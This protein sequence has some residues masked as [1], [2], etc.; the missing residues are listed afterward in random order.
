M[1]SCLFL[2]K[3]LLE[4]DGDYHRDP[5]MDILQG[6]KG[7]GVLSPKGMFSA[8][9]PLGAQAAMWKG[10]G[11]KVGVEFHRP[12]EQEQLLVPP[13]PRPAHCTELLLF[14]LTQDV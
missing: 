1:P 5:Q 14:S 6:V 10:G 11:K 13:W 9:P 2:E 8:N 7:S 12:K 3:L 4:G